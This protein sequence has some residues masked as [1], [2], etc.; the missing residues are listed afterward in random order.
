MNKK[1][2]QCKIEKKVTRTVHYAT[3]D[4]TFCMCNE[5]GEGLNWF[6]REEIDVLYHQSK[7]TEMI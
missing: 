5:D 3:D 7:R 2:H 1:I 6:T 4:G